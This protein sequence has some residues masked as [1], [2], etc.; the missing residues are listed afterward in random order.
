MKNMRCEKVTYVSGTIYEQII[1][2][3]I[4]YLYGT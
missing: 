1:P 4:I 2:F 3:L